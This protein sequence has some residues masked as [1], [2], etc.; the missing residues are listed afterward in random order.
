MSALTGNRKP[1]K[2]ISA[3]LKRSVAN[4]VRRVYKCANRN[5]THYPT[6]YKNGPNL[7]GVGPFLSARARS[8]LL[9]LGT[10]CSPHTGHSIRSKSTRRTSAGEITFPHFGHTL[11]I[12]AS[13]FSRLIFRERGMRAILIPTV[14]Y[15]VCTLGRSAI[16]RALGTLANEVK[17]TKARAAYDGFRIVDDET[18]LGSAQK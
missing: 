11:S 15:A 1:A 9:G 18:V 2:L 16:A 5:I 12:D 3:Y 10:N 17:I 8:H 6:R 4:L 14:T 7:G 13:T